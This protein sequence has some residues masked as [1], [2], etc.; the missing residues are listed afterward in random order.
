MLSTVFILQFFVP[1]SL[2]QTTDSFNLKATGG[3]GFVDLSWSSIT[4]AES[5]WIYRGPEPGKEFLTP[6]T[7][8]PIKT[9]TFHDDINIENNK[10]YCY[11]ITAVDKNADEIARSLEACTT[12][13]CAEER[14]CKLVL[15]YQSDNV[16]YWVNES[17]KGPME[18]APIIINSRLFLVI[19]YVTN[20]I[21]GI[22]LEWLASERKVTINSSIGTR[23]ELWIDKKDAKVNGKS[24]QIDPNNP[25]VVP[26]IRDGRTLMPMRFIAEKLGATGEDGIKWFEATKIVQLT[27]SDPVCTFD[28]FR[29][30][31]V[32]QIQ[33]NLFEFSIEYHSSKGQVQDVVLDLTKKGAKSTIRLGRSKE[34]KIVMGEFMSVEVPKPKIQEVSTEKGKAKLFIWEVTLEPG[35]M[36]F[37]RFI[38][39][40]EVLPEK[41][42]LGPVVAPLP[43]ALSVESLD[44]NSLKI[45]EEST[46]QGYF[47]HEP[48][49]MLVNDFWKIYEQ[50]ARQPGKGIFVRLPVGQKIA[51]GSFISVE[52]TLEKSGEVSLLNIS[53]IAFREDISIGIK[54]KITPI[55]FGEFVLPRSTS[56]YAI[57]FHGVRNDVEVVDMYGSSHF[58]SRLR[59]DIG[60]DAF[61]YYPTALALGVPKENIKMFFG[62]G[63]SEIDLISAEDGDGNPFNF[64]WNDAEYRRTQ[65]QDAQ[66]WWRAGDGWGVRPATIAE[67]DAG[68]AE[69]ADNISHLP[70]NQDVELYILTTSHGGR[71]VDSNEDDG[72]GGVLGTFSGYGI[73]D[74][75]MVA[76]INECFVAA[77][78]TRGF[79]VRS[80]HQFCESG[81]FVDDYADE[82]KYDGTNTVQV[83][84]AARYDESSWG[85]WPPT[86]D[87]ASYAEAGSTFSIPFINR[88]RQ[89]IGW[90]NLPTW[91][92]NTL[93][94]NAYDYGK[95]HDSYAIANISHPMYWHSSGRFAYHAGSAFSHEDLRKGLVFEKIPVPIPLPEPDPVME[96]AIQNF[97][98][99]GVD[100]SRLE[101][102]ICNCLIS[103]K[104]GL[105]NSFNIINSGIQK[106]SVTKIEPIEGVLKK[107]TNNQ[108]L[109]F[110]Q[111]KECTTESNISKF[112]V[113]PG[114]ST[115]LYMCIAPDRLE[116]QPLDDNG[117]MATDDGL[118][119]FVTVPIKITYSVT[120]GKDI[121]TSFVYAYARIRVTGANWEI[122]QNILVQ[123]Q[124][125]FGKQ[126]VN[127]W[128]NDDQ[129][130]QVSISPSPPLTDDDIIAGPKTK[131]TINMIVKT[132]IAQSFMKD[133]LA[134]SGFLNGFKLE[135]PI[136][137]VNNGCW[138]YDFWYD[139]SVE[140]LGKSRI[141]NRWT[142]ELPQKD[143]TKQ[144][145]ILKLEPGI[146][147]VEGYSAILGKHEFKIIVKFDQSFV[148][149]C[150]LTLIKRTVTINLTIEF[151][152]PGMLR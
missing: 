117:Y 78:E 95:A 46:I 59:T 70:A 75:H 3:C 121:Y 83:A 74:N 69:I 103:D 28:G 126:L 145:I 98:R 14:T 1:T 137:E 48:Y 148:R 68:F 92:D 11:Y 139:V 49:P 57:I 73:S 87:T 64:S 138:G 25:K 104:S 129:L 79:K 123:R 112:D 67:L 127:T 38:A 97:C 131:G 109:F 9:T 17:E 31:A 7:D 119:A 84:T 116:A 42:F 111:T 140:N 61:H 99:I 13:R 15:K 58:Y 23:I 22:T 65:E 152:E 53:K 135:L 5:Y 77:G 26:I 43:D 146:K 133:G 107:C 56:R 76:K 85:Q 19:R 18:T 86:E 96:K 32:N 44:T 101:Y 51:D 33:G 54:N 124:N 106:F 35:L 114:S 94:K 122:R 88:I 102:D 39:N 47:T 89:I 151:V 45:G 110:S 149:C 40:K 71:N 147:S 8:F 130:T 128:K 132:P 30:P 10:Q 81:E 36:H 82:F 134:V 150:L 80:L 90:G 52:S 115:T 113:E 143:L 118:P 142:I 24:I 136:N 29:Y 50:S 27:L 63:D 41:G 34:N 144:S 21:K 16:Y 91:E 12:T 37:Y 4:G 66:Q 2:S 93:W 6:L 20:E 60:G 62:S 105:S 120:S 55:D 100:T 141:K 72:Y 108:A 125:N